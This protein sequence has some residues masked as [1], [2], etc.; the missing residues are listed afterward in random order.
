M[1]MAVDSSFLGFCFLEAGDV[2]G[3]TYHLYTEMDS[4]MAGH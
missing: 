4:V 2:M 1:A 3:M